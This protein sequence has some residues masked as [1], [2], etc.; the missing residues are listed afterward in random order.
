MRHWVRSIKFAAFLI[1]TIS[2]VVSLVASGTAEIDLPTVLVGRW[3]GE[4][5]QAKSHR[6]ADTLD[7]ILI[8]NSVAKTDSGWIA[9][10]AFGI[11]GKELTPVQATLDTSAGAPTL[12][13]LTGSNGR[14]SLRV[15]DDQNLLGSFSKGSAE[16]TLK[17]RKVK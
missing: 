3:E 12:S 1:I 6:G 2:T 5:S 11:S 13:F 8:I 14:V 16:R 17:L 10:C 15:H 7:R 4:L 9:D